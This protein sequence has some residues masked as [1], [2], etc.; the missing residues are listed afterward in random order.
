MSTRTQHNTLTDRISH[1]SV[2][3]IHWF[4]IELSKSR[5]IGPATSIISLISM[6][7]DFALHA[8]AALVLCALN[9]SISTP[10][11]HIISL[12]HLLNVS[13]ETPFL[14]PSYVRIL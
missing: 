5:R 3:I 13:L 10:A 2:I 12:I 7:A 6:S 1:M 8:A 11:P 4:R 9:I 14:C